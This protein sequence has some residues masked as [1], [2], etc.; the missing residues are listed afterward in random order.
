MLIN[1]FKID[2]E[3]IER[4]C[5]IIIKIG[6]NDEKLLENLVTY[7]NEARL[8]KSI[9]NMFDKETISNIIK[10]GGIRELLRE[11]LRIFY[12]I[13][14]ISDIESQNITIEDIS[15]KFK[16][17]DIGDVRQ[18]EDHVKRISDTILT[19]RNCVKIFEELRRAGF[20]DRISQMLI[21]VLYLVLLGTDFELASIEKVPPH[22]D[23]H[24]IKIF[25][26]T[27][28]LIPCKDVLNR[29]A[30]ESRYIVKIVPV[31][32][33]LAPDEP[34][35]TVWD[36]LR[37]RSIEIFQ[38]FTERVNISQIILSIYLSNIGRRLCIFNDDSKAVDEYCPIKG[39]M[40]C[41]LSDA[42]KSYR[43]DSRIMIFSRRQ[44][45]LVLRFFNAS[46][47]VIERS[48][49]CIVL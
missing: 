24:I 12:T 44:M 8:I 39:V 10:R 25:L 34:F 45:R 42:C 16:E 9:V 3:E 19:S 6:E 17:S 21:Y 47:D 4:L 38:I 2:R 20:K 35:K 26:R 22:V 7:S 28:A 40:T 27:G 41:P 11:I 37:R 18:F 5:E 33:K 31:C 29:Y 14:K 48:C 1:A 49:E 15:R 13:N 23:I 46:R 32:A 43:G 36:V 30:G